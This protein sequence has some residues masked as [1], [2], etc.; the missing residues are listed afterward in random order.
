MP[1]LFG[2][3]LSPKPAVRKQS[4][5]Q[6]AMQP[7]IPPQQHGAF[8]MI[9]SPFVKMP[10]GKSASLKSYA[11]SKIEY[12]WIGGMS[13]PRAISCVLG[14]AAIRCRSDAR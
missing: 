9:E 12:S 10:S 3:I 4:P 7:L 5:L 11:Y 2:F 6:Q 14:A 13:N 8:C 1:S